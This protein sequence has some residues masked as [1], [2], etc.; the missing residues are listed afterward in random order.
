MNRNITTLLFDLD[1]TL[2][3]TNELII[4]SFTHTLNK[5]FPNEYTRDDILPFIG[6]TLRE[7]FE[8][9]AKD[10]VDELIQ[11][12]REHNL[13]FHDELVTEYKGVHETIKILSEQGFKLGIVTTKML[14]TVMKGLTL[15]KLDQYFPVIIA[16]DHVKH[17]KPNPEPV[18]KALDK[19]DSKPDE[20]IMIGDNYHDIL[21]G[22]NAGTL[23]AGVG[24]SIKG[25]DYLA[26]FEPDFILKEMKD[27]LKIVGVE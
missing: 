13:R 24:W 17:A 7:T 16:L 5:Y 4:S 12:Y 26:S 22:K 1:G 3:N 9:I 14:D 20:A 2:I 25:A 11:C 19:L 8:S 18:F 10:K 15:T 27:L 21:A 23:T 6:P